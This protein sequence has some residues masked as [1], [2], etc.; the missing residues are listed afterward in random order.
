MCTSRAGRATF[1]D[2]TTGI[3]QDAA[4]V[5]AEKIEILLPID[6][7]PLVTDV[8]AGRL[9][10]SRIS[11]RIRDGGEHC[12]IVKRKIDEALAATPLMIR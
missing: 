8:S 6:C 4:K 11:L 9:L 10:N 7:R 12:W 5:L 3:T 1:N 2:D